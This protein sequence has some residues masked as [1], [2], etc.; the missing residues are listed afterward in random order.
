MRKGN[1]NVISYL[2][3]VGV[4]PSFLCGNDLVNEIHISSP[5]KVIF[6]ISDLNREIV[7]CL[8]SLWANLH[9]YVMIRLYS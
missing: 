8:F 3:D 6:Y 1:P 5:V 9:K 7:V 2:N 4:H